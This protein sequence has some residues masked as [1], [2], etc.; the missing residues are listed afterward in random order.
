M[1]SK[2]RPKVLPA[3]TPAL[4]KPSISPHC[5]AQF[6][7]PVRM[8]HTADTLFPQSPPISPLAPIHTQQT[9]V[10]SCTSP[11][12]LHN[13]IPLATT[14]P[15]KTRMPPKLDGSSQPPAGHTLAWRPKP[16]LPNGPP[17]PQTAT[18]PHAM[19]TQLRPNRLR[20]EPIGWPTQNDS[21]QPASAMADRTAMPVASRLDNR[22]HR[23][24]SVDSPQKNPHRPAAPET[25]ETIRCPSA[26]F[27][28]LA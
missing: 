5:L 2:T 14:N 25:S 10:P 16:S 12:L 27:P 20:P 15:P 28:F 18:L 19:P 22:T 7:T 23:P 8:R 13:S 4:P 3:T 21:V 1:P 26:T 17:F 6:R 24:M 11:L 9:P